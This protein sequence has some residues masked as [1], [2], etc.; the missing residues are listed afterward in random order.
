ME[1]SGNFGKI[2]RVLSIYT[3][4]LNDKV[5]NKAAEAADFCVNER[6]IQRDIEDIREFIQNHENDE[7]REIIYDREAR[8]YR[9]ER[10]KWVGLKS[11]E[12]LAICKILLESRALRKDD[13]T[14]ILERLIS[15]CSAPGERGKIKELI[16]NEEFHYIEPRHK[17]HIIET[18]WKIG[19]AVREKRFIEMSYYRMTDKLTVTRKVKPVAI[20]FSEFYFYLMAFIDDKDEARVNFSVPNDCFPTIYRIDRIKKLTVLDEKFY[21]PY[22]DRFEEGEFRKRVQFMHGGKLRRIKFE[23]RGNDIDSIL[24]RLPTAKI[25][26]ENDGVYTLTVEVFGDGIYMWLRSQ[27]S[28]VKVL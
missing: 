7:N 13:M 19:Q 12:L 4:L 23:Y 6:S 18:I 1:N 20:M 21:I 24:D 26:S 9:L 5:I 3:R 28:L 16:R 17:S 2:E 11:G 14:D 8:G 15:C 10:K 22:R 27:G 25:I